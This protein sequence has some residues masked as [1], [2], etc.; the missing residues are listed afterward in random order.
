MFKQLH[1]SM[2]PVL[3]CYLVNFVMTSHVGLQSGPDQHVIC[4]AVPVP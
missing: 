1:A 4:D 3:T 2:T